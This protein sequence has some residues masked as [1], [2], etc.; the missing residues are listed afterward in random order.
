MANSLDINEII[1]N[2]DYD[3]CHLLSDAYPGLNGNNDM[4]DCDE[5]ILENVNSLYYNIDD[6]C[7]RR[8]DLLKYN[9]NVIH[10][11]IS[12]LPAHFD[13]LKLVLSQFDAQ[14][15]QF[16]CILL[17]ETS[18]NDNNCDMFD[19]PSYHK[20]V[21]RH[22]R[23]TTRGGVAI[24]VNNR[25]TFNIRDDLAMYD[26]HIFESIVV[27]VSKAGKTFL[28]GEVYRVPNSNN[29]QC[30][31]YYETVVSRMVAENK[32]T[33]IGTDQN[34]D[35]INISHGPTHDL[36]DV[37]FASGMAPVISRPTRITDRTATLIDNLYVNNTQLDKFTSGILTLDLSDHF[38][39]Y[40]SVGE[41]YQGKNDK[42]PLTFTYR[43]LDDSAICAV[44]SLLNCTDCKNWIPGPKNLYKNRLPN[45]AD[46]IFT[47]TNNE[48]FIFYWRPYW[49]NIKSMQAASSRTNI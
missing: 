21:S 10:L 28:I 31:N 48:N 6:L 1:N 33:V 46:V 29:A 41:Y 20:L 30:L 9:M 17:C 8:S 32:T 36:L 37:F 19:I 39:V 34:Y 23:H 24:Y 42:A 13:Q 16:D 3:L 18:L 5:N 49:I 44:R 7:A 25:Y 22:R 11:N 40:V 45:E 47:I 12:S 26:E 15:I 35:Y 14:N 43:P 2:S 4:N 27:E 38:A